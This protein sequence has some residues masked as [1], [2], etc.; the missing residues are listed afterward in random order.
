M[1]RGTLSDEEKS[2]ISAKLPNLDNLLRT[3]PKT[4]SDFSLEKG[5]QNY[6]VIFGRLL[7]TYT[8]RG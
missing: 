6:E 8:S 5:G 2:T 3:C 1:L 4:T 7:T